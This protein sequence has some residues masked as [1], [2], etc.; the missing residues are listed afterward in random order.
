MTK[1]SLPPV[2]LGYAVL[3]LVAGGAAF[4]FLK[5]GARKTAA[6]VGSV[7]GELVAG[8]IEGLGDSIGVPR[9]N[10]SECDRALREG[11][12]WDAS[13][14]CPA[15]QFLGG[16]FGSGVGPSPINRTGDSSG[17]PSY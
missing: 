4:W 12:L 3:A 5:G 15:G 11:R 9:T 17:V 2:V 14:K 8:V 10:E 6:A 1:I 16:I 13:F 7:P